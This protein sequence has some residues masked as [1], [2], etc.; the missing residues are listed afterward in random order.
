MVKRIIYGIFLVICTLS[1]ASCAAPQPDDTSSHIH[2]W[3]DG[4]VRIKPSC[5][6]EGAYLYRCRGCEKDL[7]VSIPATGHNY[8]SA[9]LFDAEAHWNVCTV[10]GALS[11]RLPH[12]FSGNVCTICGMTKTHEHTWLETDVIEANCTQDGTIF[13]RCTGCGDETTMIIPAVGHTPSDTLRFDVES[14]FHLCTA[15]GEPVNRERHFWNGGLICSDCGATRTETDE[16]HEHDW[17]DGTIL[18]SPTCTQTGVLEC[19]C[20]DCGQ[21][22]H[23]EIPPT[24]HDFSG[25][26]TYDENVHQKTCRNC[27]ATEG[28]EHSWQQTEVL[29]PPTCNEIG[30]ALFRCDVCGAEKRD[31]ISTLP[32]T[33]QSWQSDETAHWKQCVSCGQIFAKTSHTWRQTSVTP[34]DCTTS[35]SVLLVCQECGREQTEQ[36]PPLGH[37]SEVWEYD[38]TSHW[39]RCSRCSVKYDAA[40]HEWYAGICECGASRSDGCLHIESAWQS[41]EEFHSKT[42]SVCGELLFSQSHTWQ[43]I[44]TI[45]ATCTSQGYATYSCAQCAR[46]KQIPLPALG[47]IESAWQ[48]DEESHSKTCS[49]CGEPLISEPH[50]MTEDNVC[51]VCG[52]QAQ[53]TQELI[54]RTYILATQQG[55]IV[56][57]LTD[58]TLEEVVIPSV[59]CS[60]P[61]LAVLNTA[62]RGCT[63]LRSIVL[64]DN[65]QELFSGLF[66]EC[67]NLEKIHFGASVTT[68]TVCAY[69]FR[70][71]TKL[72]EVTVSSN[73]PH[74]YALRNCLISRT[75]NALLLGGTTDDLPDVLSIADDAFHGRGLLT[76]ITIPDSVTSLGKRVFFSCTSL[77][78]IT[79]GTGI[80]TLPESTFELCPKLTQV[81][82]RGSLTDVGSAAFRG[83]VSLQEISLPHVIFIDESA[84][85]DCEALEKITLGAELQ[86]I[87]QNAFA[88]CV[89]L[90]SARYLGDEN[91][92]EEIN[93]ESGNRWLEFADIIFEG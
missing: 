76:K 89:S 15:C 91:G 16:E 2:D 63:N 73:N 32:H 51:S 55:Y 20:R 46:E 48:S 65:V 47:H 41:D 39:R 44:D 92:W 70:T 13:Y 35:G 45:D 22:T 88:N 43:L 8:S 80:D 66:D 6:T 10:C 37:R 7:S 93:I 75:D 33:A 87:S 14:H 26:Y 18:H 53:Y 25:E 42:C 82:V 11:Q 23:V 78:E 74:L 49:V 3:D 29:L 85:A 27:T 81:A 38:N 28:S 58:N 68:S 62:F 40:T 59:Y 34:S 1:F 21:T 12:D 77:E 54:F 50:V 56:T 71:C 79:L 60:Q 86:T 5:T 9:P 67:V 36:T 61:V 90:V 72:R 31:P 4:A 64:G 83:C 19:I 57:G 30:M 17:K 52:R 24:G 84:F 69:D